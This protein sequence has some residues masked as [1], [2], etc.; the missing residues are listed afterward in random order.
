MTDYFK[1]VQE[2]DEKG[3]KDLSSNNKNDSLDKFL[4]TV[5][6]EE[7]KLKSALSE[8][9]NDEKVS[10]NLNSDNSLNS[11]WLEK[12]ENIERA[13]EEQKSDFPKRR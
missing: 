10:N 9:D 3:V 11:D 8:L 7:D 13:L 12:L 5:K 1:R 6:K 2:I 4:E